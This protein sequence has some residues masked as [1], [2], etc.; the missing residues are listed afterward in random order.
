[1]VL[2]ILSYETALM[3]GVLRMDLLKKG[4]LRVHIQ[5][6]LLVLEVVEEVGNAASYF[7]YFACIFLSYS[8]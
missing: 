2:Q 7:P 6:A 5:G 8:D 3:K 1:M 4:H